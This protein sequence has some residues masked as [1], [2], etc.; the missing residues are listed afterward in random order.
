MKREKSLFS[1]IHGFLQPTKF[2]GVSKKA[3]FGICLKSWCFVKRV[4]LGNLIGFVS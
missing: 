2:R 1:K 3:Y 4:L